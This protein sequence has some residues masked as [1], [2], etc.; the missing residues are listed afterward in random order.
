MSIAE[1]LFE[2]Q[3]SYAHLIFAPALYRDELTKYLRPFAQEGKVVNETDV[4][5]FFDS[6][7]EAHQKSRH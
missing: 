6:L 7:T 3:G 1:D 2:C 4:K 5:S